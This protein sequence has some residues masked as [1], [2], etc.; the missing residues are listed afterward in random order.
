MGQVIPIYWLTGL[1]LI[2]Y[3][4]QKVRTDYKNIVYD[5]DSN[6]N[7]LRASPAFSDTETETMVKAFQEVSGRRLIDLSN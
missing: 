4:V 3:P 5:L 6:T 1:V 7:A 2:R